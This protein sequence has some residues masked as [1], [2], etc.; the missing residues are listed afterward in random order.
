MWKVNY[1]AQLDLGKPRKIHSLTLVVYSRTASKCWDLIARCNLFFNNSLFTSQPILMFIF[2]HF[3]CY[4]KV[5]ELIDA[6]IWWSQVWYE[7]WGRQNRPPILQNRST[8]YSC[9]YEYQV[10]PLRLLAVYNCQPK[11]MV[12]E[13]LIYLCVGFLIF[14]FLSFC[15]DTFYCLNAPWLCIHIASSRAAS[16]LWQMSLKNIHLSGLWDWQAVA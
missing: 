7:N 10:S 5:F 9:M 11:Y 1:P 6:Q 15:K 14:D 2:V 12:N 16:V 8:L 4:F 13:I 3:L